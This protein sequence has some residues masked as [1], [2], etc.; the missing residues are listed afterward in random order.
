[1]KV[2]ALKP[3]GYL[4]KTLP[5]ADIIKAIDDFFEKQKYKNM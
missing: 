4:L 3:D 1:M 5:P 2:M